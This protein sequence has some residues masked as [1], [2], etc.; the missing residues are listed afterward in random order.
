VQTTGRP[1][2]STVNGLP[3]GALN[4]T[5]DGT[6]VQDNLISSQDGFFTFV[7]PRIDA[8]DEVTVSTATPGAESSGDGAAQIKFVTRS[9]TNDFT[10]SIYWYHREPTLSANYYFNN[11]LLPPDPGTGRAPMNRVLLNQYGARA[12]GPIIIPGVFNGRDKAFFFVNHEQYRLPESRLRQ[13]VILNQDAMRGI[14]RYQTAAGVQTVDV[15]ALAAANGFPST[16]D[17]TIGSLLAAIRATTS[18]GGIT[19]IA[20]E[21]NRE[22]F[23][24]LGIGG[25]KRYFTTVRFDFNIT[26]K[27][28]LEN[29]WN[30]QEF[31]GGQTDFLNNIDPSFPGF[32]N[33]F[34]Q[35]SQRFTKPES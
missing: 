13:R 6:D 33:T 21:L 8:I 30:Y 14:F 16:I 23:S 25:H 18:Q 11:L 24:F 4:I 19:P 22:N 31:N 15:L 17:P 9:G 26:D 20:N 29:I 28:H 2:T 27:H 1:R 35:N 12:G 34:G 10:G 5:I 7:R 3:K 32:P